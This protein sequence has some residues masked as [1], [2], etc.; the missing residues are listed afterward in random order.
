[1]DKNQIEVE[2]EVIQDF[3]CSNDERSFVLCATLG[4]ILVIVA[5]LASGCSSNTGWQFQVGISPIK[6]VR[7]QQVLPV[8]QAKGRYSMLP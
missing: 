5:M 3:E 1:M 6:Q 4:T 2:K 8:D 7:N